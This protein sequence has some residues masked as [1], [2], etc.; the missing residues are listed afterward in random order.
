MITFIN[1]VDSNA[2]INAYKKKIGL[3]KKEVAGHM[4]HINFYRRVAKLS[5]QIKSLLE[6]ETRD[7]E[8]IEKLRGELKLEFERWKSE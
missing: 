4:V 7:E 2:Q 1:L 3:N 8:E 6:N 5:H